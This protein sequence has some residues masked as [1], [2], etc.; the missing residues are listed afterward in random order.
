[1]II[2]NTLILKKNNMRIGLVGEAPNDTQSI[3]NLMEKSYNSGFDFFFMLDRIN[4][5]NLDSQKTKRFLRIEYETK[6]PDLI[7]FIRDLDSVLPNKLKLYDRKLYFTNSN[8]VV[9]KKGV[10]LL[11]IYEIEAL[12]L[13]DIEVFNKIYNSKLSSV[14]NPMLIEEPKEYLRSKEKKYNESH[15]PDIFKKLRFKKAMGCEYFSQFIS[16]FNNIV[17]LC[18]Q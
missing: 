3:Q 5:S 14:K 11:H 15:N 10:Y 16:N 6:K 1:M 17:A 12:I 7:I 2:G 13:S 4:G 9:D 18:N 8:K